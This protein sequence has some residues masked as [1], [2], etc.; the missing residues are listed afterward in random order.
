MLCR[1]SV[2]NLLTRRSF[3]ALSSAVLALPAR[4]A[5]GREQDAPP[6]SADPLPAVT[7]GR[8][9]RVVPRLGFGSAPIG[10]LGSAE[11][12]VEVVK[13]AIR[14]GV[15]YLDT[16]PSYSRGRAERRVGAAVAGCGVDRGEFFIATKTQRRDGAG[17]RRELEESLKRL[18]MDYVDALQVHE[19]HG[20]V[21]RLF[22]AGAVVPEL[23]KARDEGLIRHIGVTGHR[24]PGYLVEA[25]LRYE[26][27]TALVPVNPLDVKHLSFI[28]DFLPVAA[29]RRTAVIAMKVFAGGRMLA[30]GEF[31]AGELLRYALSTPPVAAA[32]PGCETVSHV[33]EAHA[34]VSGFKALTAQ[35]RASLEARAGAH[36][37]KESEW[38]KPGR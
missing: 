4:L 5:R 1:E 31:T 13:A 16:A 9:G 28:R 6:A 36:R 19:V 25:V 20:D 29:Q 23:E 26:F 14:L 32:V 30:D 8:T 27:A 33:E 37:G 12:A 24:D 10:R 18:G 35:E 15:R 7:L 2:M 21:D 11:D 38:Y 34:A 22:G 17:A 3:L